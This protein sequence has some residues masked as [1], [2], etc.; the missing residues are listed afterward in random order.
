MKILVLGATGMLGHKMFQI[1]KRRFPNTQATIR[2]SINDQRW[3]K[4]ALFQEGK[5]IDHFDAAD[6]CRVEKILTDLRPQVIVNCVGMI[7]Q[8]PEARAVIPNLTLNALLPHRLAEICHGFGGRLIQISTDCV[9][10]GSRGNYTEEDQ[11]DADDLYGRTKYLGEVV[12]ENVLTLRTSMIGRELVHRQSLLEWFLSQNSS[13]VRGFKHAWYSG[14]TTNHLAEAVGDLIRDFP[15]LSGLYHL[16]GQ[17]ITKYDLLCLLRE[18]FRLHIEI[19]P[20]E[21]FYCDR[22]LDGGKFSRETGYSCPDWPSLVAQLV[23]DPTP[24]QLWRN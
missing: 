24:Y 19:V 6:L 13:R 8:R 9:F 5:I 3:R 16:T 2:G 11:S 20:D 10:S 4:I 7:K 22:S 21:S 15:Q 23:D 14:V 12:G 18:A 1:L 17:T